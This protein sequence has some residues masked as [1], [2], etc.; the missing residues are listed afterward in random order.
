MEYANFYEKYI[1]CVDYDRMTLEEIASELETIAYNEGR[2]EIGKL[3]KEKYTIVL[4][5]VYDKLIENYRICAMIFV[6][7]YDQKIL[8]G[9]LF[10]VKHYY[11]DGPDLISIISKNKQ[12]RNVIPEIN[13]QDLVLRLSN[14]EIYE[15]KWMIR[16]FPKSRLIKVLMENR[17]LIFSSRKDIRNN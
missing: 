2:M 3:I 5:L 4:Y 7:Y 15:I 12:Y 1:Y 16:P 9:E 6:D 13:L 14:D 8:R 17:N 10:P 11:D